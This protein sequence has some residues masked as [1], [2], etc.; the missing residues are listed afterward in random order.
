[1][2]VPA[3]HDDFFGASAVQRIVPFLRPAEP[4][5]TQS[6]PRVPHRVPGVAWTG[7]TPALIGAGTERAHPTRI[8]TG[9]WRASPAV[10]RQR[11]HHLRQHWGSAPPTYA[12]VHPCNICAGSGPTPSHPTSAPGLLRRAG[13]RAAAHAAHRGARRGQGRPA[14]GA[15][16]V[17]AAVSSTHPPAF[18]RALACAWLDLGLFAV[19]VFRAVV[20]VRAGLLCAPEAGSPLRPHIRAGTGLTPRLCS[21]RRCPRPER[22]LRSMQR[23][24]CNRQNSSRHNAT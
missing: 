4:V 14:D 6:T 3:S 24:T 11:S 2:A 20:K 18:A 7:L 17:R 13:K 5:S 9:I 8:G 15:A 22:A 21:A 16:A 12:G 23:A 19:M 1:M 10:P